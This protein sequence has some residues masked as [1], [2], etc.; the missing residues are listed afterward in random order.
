MAVR[1]TSGS[2]PVTGAP[3]LGAQGNGAAV[4]G[5]G[6][7]GRWAVVVRGVRAR[8]G[9]RSAPA[10]T[11]QARADR[12]TPP[13]NP[14]NREVAPSMGCRRKK[15][16]RGRHLAP[17]RLAPASRAFR[18]FF[19]P[20]PRFFAILVAQFGPFEG[21]IEVVFRFMVFGFLLRFSVAGPNRS[22][23]LRCAARVTAGPC[24][25]PEAFASCE[26]RRE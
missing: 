10:S 9:G 20:E 24:Q 14:T 8:P 12:P 6:D 16:G 2:P 19:P 21:R 3:G 4:D 11:P 23:S 26:G 18:L 22:V 17:A 5:W 25:S 15:R 1:L 7:V 13:A